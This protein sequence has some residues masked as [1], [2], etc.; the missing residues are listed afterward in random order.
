[1]KNSSGNNIERALI[2]IAGRMRF[3]PQGVNSFIHSACIEYPQ[4]VKTLKFYRRFKDK[5]AA[6][7]GYCSWQKIIRSF[8]KYVSPGYVV[9]NLEPFSLEDINTCQRNCC[10]AVPEEKG[11]YVLDR[12]VPMLTAAYFKKAPT[13]YIGK[14]M[15]IALANTDVPVQAEPEKVLDAFFV[16]LPENFFFEVLDIKLG[17]HDAFLVTSAAGMNYGISTS[18]KIFSYMTRYLSYNTVCNNPSLHFAICG[19]GKFMATSTSWSDSAETC[20]PQVSSPDIPKD[21]LFTAEIQRKVSNLI[22]NIILIYNYQPE[23]VQVEKSS[24][25]IQGKGFGG[26]TT[27]A[28]Y[29]IR[30]VGK[31]FI[32]QFSTDQQSSNQSLKRIFKSHWRRGHWH[33]Y[34]AGTGRKKQILKW[35]QPVYVKG[36][37]LHS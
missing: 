37:N 5:Y 7:L 11:S 29:P 2:N 21:Q 32:R 35:V 4:N 13:L 8:S 17:S 18:K 28:E 30:W 9:N 10:F 20:L 25:I 31:N 19:N 15:A 1:M 27:K 24:A 3:T 6:P 36:V 26:K 33:H 34:W 23:Y 14:E 22:K 12:L 16:C